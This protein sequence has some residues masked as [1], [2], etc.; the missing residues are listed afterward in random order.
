MFVLV[1]PCTFIPA[2]ARELKTQKTSPQ[3]KS[4]M[5]EEL[6]ALQSE[7]LRLKIL[8]VQRAGIDLEVLL[9]ALIEGSGGETAV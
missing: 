3:K 5:A 2:P 6:D 4:Q 9:D 1:M 8:K 7:T